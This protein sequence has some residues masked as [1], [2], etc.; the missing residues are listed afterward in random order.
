MMGYTRY[1]TLSEFREDWE[2]TLCRDEIVANLFYACFSGE[3]R[4][5]E[6]LWAASVESEAG[7]LLSIRRGDKGMVLYHTGDGLADL[8]TRLIQGMTADQYWPDQFVG[9]SET[10]RV[11]IPLIN[12]KGRTFQA[13]KDMRVHKLTGVKPVPETDGTFHRIDTMLSYLVD[14]DMAFQRDVGNRV[15][16]DEV[17]KQVQDMIDEGRLYGWMVGDRCVSMATKT[18]KTPHGRFLSHVY[19]PTEERDKGYATSCV[20]ALSRLLL[21][22]GNEYCGLFTDLSNPVS[23]HIY[24]KMGYEPFCDFTLYRLEETLT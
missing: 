17:A 22:E 23:N 24:Q 1:E 16:R 5:E 14:Y 20:A 12:G 9:P 6:G 3:D 15:T 7:L 21:D 18:R 10:L 19:T 4:I 2:K 13:V 11:F 8:C